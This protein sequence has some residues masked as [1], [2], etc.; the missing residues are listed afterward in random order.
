MGDKEDLVVKR[1]LAARLLATE[2]ENG[3]DQRANDH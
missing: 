3:K 2:D 1:E